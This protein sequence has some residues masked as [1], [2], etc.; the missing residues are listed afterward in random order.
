MVHAHM[1][2]HREVGSDGGDGHDPGEDAVPISVGG[3][4]QKEVGAGPDL[5]VVLTMRVVYPGGR[6]RERVYSSRSCMSRLRVAG[7]GF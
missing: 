4:E 3:V 7:W 2:A 6:G 1:P 5:E